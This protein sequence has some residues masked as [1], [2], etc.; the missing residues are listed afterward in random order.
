MGAKPAPTRLFSLLAQVTSS[1][2]T[3]GLSWLSVRTELTW[4]VSGN[5]I[6]GIRNEN[7]GP[8]P[9]H[10]ALE[11]WNSSNNNNNNNRKFGVKRART[12]VMSLDWLVNILWAHGDQN[13]AS[14]VERLPE[15]TIRIAAAKA[16]K[17][18]LQVE[19][20]GRVD[21]GAPPRLSTVNRRTIYLRVSRKYLN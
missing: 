9:V 10:T 20:L 21:F 13:S 1:P 12:S 2:E 16:S 14:A 17:W 5:R 19:M 3:K 7:P 18:R 11:L 6:S 8:L 4:T 15:V